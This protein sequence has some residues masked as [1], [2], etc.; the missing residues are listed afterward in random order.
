MEGFM[1]KYA[2]IG[3]MVLKEGCREEYVAL[4][5]AYAHL[6]LEEDGTEVYA[7]GLS[8]DDPNVI[9]T[10][11]VYASEAAFLAHRHRPDVQV[12]REKMAE[13]RACPNEHFDLVPVYAVG[14]GKPNDSLFSIAADVA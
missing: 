14:L 8:A 1:G 12:Y 5:K 2:F 7:F 3:K 11:E 10:F 13:L 9:W 6:Y 4:K